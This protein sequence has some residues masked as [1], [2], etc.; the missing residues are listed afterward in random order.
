M[1]TSLINKKPFDNNDSITVWAKSDGFEDIINSRKGTLGKFIGTSV[2]VP[3]G[4]TT[5]HW[6]VFKNNI[7]TEHS[8]TISL[9]INGARG[10]TIEY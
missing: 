7:T 5:I 8:D 10:Y 2:P 9:E 6:K 3:S 1:E 4:F